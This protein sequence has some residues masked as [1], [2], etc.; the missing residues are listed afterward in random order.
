MPHGP[1]PRAPWRV[2]RRRGLVAGHEDSLSG[3][4][5]GASPAFHHWARATIG[6]AAKVVA[7][8]R[9]PRGGKPPQPPPCRLVVPMTRQNRESP[10]RSTSAARGRADAGERRRT[11]APE[12]LPNVARRVYPAR[13][14]R[15]RRPRSRASPRTTSTSASLGGGRPLRTTR[16]SAAMSRTMGLAA[17]LHRGTAAAADR[18]STPAPDEQWE[19]RSRPLLSG[20]RSSLRLPPHCAA[21]C[22]VGRAP[23]AEERRAPRP[24]VCG[25]E[26]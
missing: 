25:S 26:A 11:Q 20:G 17:L 18:V 16:G 6:I 21:R 19:R 8:I 23:A 24:P 22:S 2:D 14:S 15:A 3:A 7:A 9:P 12:P 13:T 10:R 4:C 1:P 5:R